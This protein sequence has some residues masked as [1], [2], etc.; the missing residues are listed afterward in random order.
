VIERITSLQA[1]IKCDVNFAKYE[2]ISKDIE[3]IVA[4]ISADPAALFYAI[5]RESIE[6]VVRR[7]SGK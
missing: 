3:K 4:A 7:A 1:E 2:I 6:Q 5:P